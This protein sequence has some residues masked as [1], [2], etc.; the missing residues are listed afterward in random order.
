MP[1]ALARVVS[2]LEE[3]APL[4]HAESWDNVGLLLEPLRDRR[5]ESATPAIER[6]FFAID[7]TD[8]VL[9]EALSLDVDLVVAYHPP[10]FHALKRLR[11]SAHAERRLLA[12]AGAG[13]ALYSP[14]TALDAAPGGVNDWLAAG[15]G[16][17]TSLPLVVASE[18]DRALELKL[19]TF[20]PEGDVERVVAALAAAGAGVIG[21]YTECTSRAATL[22]TF[23][24]GE[25]ANPA[26]GT[27]GK[28]ERVDEIRLEMVCPKGALPRIAEVMRD[29]HPYEE[30]AWDVYAL[31][32]HPVLGAGV[33]R[34]VTLDEAVP[35]AALV[36]RL[37]QHLGLASLRV[38]A[39]AEHAGGAPIAR[40]LVC[41]GSGG[42]ALR[43]AESAELVLTGELSHHAVLE[44]LARGTSVVLC[45]HSS[46]ERGFLPIFAQRVR[47][48]A[49]GS[50]AVLVSTSDREPI[51][52]W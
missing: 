14:H 13:I 36:A 40:A 41:A 7:L 22:G 5:N 45:E 21:E 6:L 17:G 30:P 1:L 9:S 23:R 11:A 43:E 42:S 37:K 12:L 27:R 24:G 25:H 15:L 32:P 31:V 16:P 38:A 28:L 19:V 35:L 50:L 46:S 2:L 18:G 10:I 26:L 3:L 8:A 49:A 51:E 44:R 52:R 47:E 29:V 20:V 33:A 48:R 39:T 34:Q 4:E